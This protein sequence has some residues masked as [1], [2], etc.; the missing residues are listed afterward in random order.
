MKTLIVLLGSVM[1]ATLLFTSCDK[2]RAQQVTPVAENSGIAAKPNPVSNGKIV[3]L[4]IRDI[5]RDPCVPGNS[6]CKDIVITAP[7]PRAADVF[8]ILTI[9]TPETLRTLCESEVMT[10]YMA[11]LKNDAGFKALIAG[12]AYSRLIDDKVGRKVFAFSASPDV[13]LNA[14]TP[15]VSIRY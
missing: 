15:V 11:D 14:E 3:D 12:G 7:R 9:G 4:D 6:Y 1:I 10:T 2:D 8:V 5:H 13:P